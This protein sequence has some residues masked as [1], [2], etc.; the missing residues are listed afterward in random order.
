MALN[1]HLDLFID[2]LTISDYLQK[3]IFT[4]AWGMIQGTSDNKN[5]PLL[6]VTQK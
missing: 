1:S 2:L 6:G 4:F 3:N 5:K